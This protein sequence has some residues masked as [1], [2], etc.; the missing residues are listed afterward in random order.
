MSTSGPSK[1]DFN[2]WLL[3]SYSTNVFS[4]TRFKVQRAYHI[5][6]GK[7][8]YDMDPGRIQK[9]IRAQTGNEEDSVFE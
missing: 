8:I 9:H 5:K 6:D 3:D 1:S 4:L 7:K 2:G